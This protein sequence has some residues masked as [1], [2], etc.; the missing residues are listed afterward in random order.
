MTH[1][2]GGHVEALG[3]LLVLRGDASGALVRVALQRLTQGKESDEVQMVIEAREAQE[4]LD[5]GQWNA[6]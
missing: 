6:A 2:L 4:R 5:D 1:R 3:E